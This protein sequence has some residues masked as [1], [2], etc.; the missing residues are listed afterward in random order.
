MR[1][2][3]EVQNGRV[4]LTEEQLQKWLRGEKVTV[5]QEKGVVLY[6]Y[7]ELLSSDEMLAEEGRL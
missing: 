5:E 2:I 4:E 3:L 7:D 1:Y 6:A